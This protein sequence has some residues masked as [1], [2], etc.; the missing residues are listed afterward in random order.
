MHLF[1]SS[2]L[3]GGAL[4]TI[5]PPTITPTTGCTNVPCGCGI[6]GGSNTG[7]IVMASVVEADCIPNPAFISQSLASPGAA[8][9]TA[10]RTL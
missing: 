3:V 4:P 2:P 1:P 8:L 6:V 7:A 5:V 10:S 9:A